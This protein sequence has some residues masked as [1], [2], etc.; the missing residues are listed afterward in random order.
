L[1]DKVHVDALL[2]GFAEDAVLVDDPSPQPRL[3]PD[4]GEDYLVAVAQKA[5]AQYIVSGDARLTQLVYP[6][7]H[8]LMPREFLETSK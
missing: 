7:P 6:S 2:M 1:I 3:T 4:L 5:D 8:V